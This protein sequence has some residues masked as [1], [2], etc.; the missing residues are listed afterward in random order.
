M[1]DTAPS[2]E[3][4]EEVTYADR[5]RSTLH[6]AFGTRPQYRWAEVR[7]ARAILNDGLKAA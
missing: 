3:E 2:L 5:L 1:T 4:R 7:E 6:F